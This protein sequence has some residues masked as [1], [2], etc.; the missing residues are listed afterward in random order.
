MKK[1]LSLRGFLLAQQQ[2]IEGPNTVKLPHRS[3]ERVVSQIHQPFK[4]V[5]V[6]ST[7]ARL[8]K[9]ELRNLQ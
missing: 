8:V 9:S 4:V 1:R 5:A 3:V 2:Q 6:A 7:G